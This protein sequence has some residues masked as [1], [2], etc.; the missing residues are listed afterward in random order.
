MSAVVL[1][2]AL[3]VGADLGRQAARVVVELLDRRWRP[4]DR[5]PSRAAL[6]RGVR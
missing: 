6:R 3:L 5:L 1:V 2:A 4:P